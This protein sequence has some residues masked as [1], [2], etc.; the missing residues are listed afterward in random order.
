M[1]KRKV[2]PL[3]EV[4]CSQFPGLS[5]K[6]LTA[7]ICCR[8]IDAAGERPADPK[9]PVDPGITLQIVR[10]PYVSRGGEKLSHA[11]DVWDIDPSGLSFI[12]AGASSGGFTDCLLQYG[13]SHVYAVDVGYNQLDYSLRIDPRVSVC[14]RKNIM[15]AEP[16]EYPADSAVM[17]L[18]FR[19]VRKAAS[20][21]L[22]LTREQWI[23]VLIKPQFE[24][25][26]EEGFDG[27][28][29]DE[30]LRQQVL[31]EVIRA[32]EEEGVHV[33]DIIPSPVPGR[34]GNR[35]YLAWLAGGGYSPIG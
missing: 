23:I 21:L 1:K 11:L 25:S 34:K 24:L 10:K 4:A 31:Q 20:H 13:A 15:D 35:E 9:F 27:V 2:R 12:D 7:H 28:V 30:G 33:L 16:G 19:S 18:S 22:S 14:E 17:D 8:E 5:K 6:E 3:I 26:R 32:L 29:K